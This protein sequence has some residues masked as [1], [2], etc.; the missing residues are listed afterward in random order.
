[1]IKEIK[2]SEYD[3]NIQALIG[4][5]GYDGQKNFS[6][7]IVKNIVYIVCKKGCKESNYQLPSVY[8][9]FL[10]TSKNRQI[11]ITN[12]RM[13]VSLDNDES[14]FGILELINK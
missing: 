6:V 9:G 10:Q 2:Y 14:A 1:M 8:D 3:P 11:E 12:N 13:T 5:Y 4:K 7:T